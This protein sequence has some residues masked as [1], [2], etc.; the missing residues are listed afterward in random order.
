MQDLIS[1]IHNYRN[2]H[3]ESNLQISNVNNN[4]SNST[5]K[6]TSKDYSIQS[7]I[8]KFVNETKNYIKDLTS[9]EFISFMSKQASN[10]NKIITIKE[11]N[12]IFDSN[13]Y[14]LPLNESITNDSNKYKNN[15]EPALD[16]KTST[17]KNLVKNNDIYS[18]TNK[19]WTI[20]KDYAIFYVYLFH[21]SNYTLL[22][23]YIKDKSVNQM[24]YRLY[25]Q[26]KSSKNNCTKQ[27]EGI[28]NTRK[29]VII[30]AKLTK[31]LMT[32]R[33]YTAK[34]Q[35]QNFIENEI[36]IQDC[37]RH[38]IFSKMEVL[39]ILEEVKNRIS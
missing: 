10:L 2:S 23:N 22:K 28:N 36:G 32:K 9:N 6:L 15:L 35:L 33:N 30:F 16:E 24:K 27:D 25:N 3:Q 31:E 21:N 13:L 14:S 26:L 29:T 11:S 38:E 4:R 7:M 39:N 17:T 19:C 20:E 5:H 1:K 18:N 8:N 34:E 37:K 12:S